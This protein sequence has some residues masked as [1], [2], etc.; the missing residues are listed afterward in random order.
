LPLSVPPPA[1]PPPFPAQV[2]FASATANRWLSIRLEAIGNSI[3]AGVAALAVGLHGAAAGGGGAA[4]AAGMAG[5]SLSYA[6]SL[7]DF[8]NWALRMSTTLEMQVGGRKEE[9]EGMAGSARGANSMSKTHLMQVGRRGM[10]LGPGHN[11]A[12]GL[13]K[14]AHDRAFHHPHRLTSSFLC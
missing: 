1:P 7:T 5:L 14:R 11:P 2:G 9:G 6:V 4:V 10:P 13:R 12:P 3:I 8:L